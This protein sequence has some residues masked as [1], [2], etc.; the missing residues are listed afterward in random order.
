MFENV[1]Q[2]IFWSLMEK[3]FKMRLFSSNARILVAFKIK[4][5]LEG[6]PKYNPHM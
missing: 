2:A 4:I 3:H 5:I 1:L 6:K